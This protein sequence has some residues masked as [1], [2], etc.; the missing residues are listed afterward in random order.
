MTPKQVK[1]GMKF[2]KLT[3]RAV[4][5]PAKTGAVN[6]RHK[7]RVECECGAL[8]TVPI[9]YLTRKHTPKT[10]C[11]QCGPKSLASQ[12]PEE[13]RIWW[14]MH[15]RTENPDHVSYHHYGG[16]GIRVCDEWN[17]ARGSDGFKAFLSFVGP[18]P[19]RQYSI[20]RVD[21][22]LGY[23]PYSSNG[24]V[25]VKWATSVE[26]RANQRPYSN[27]KAT[28]GTPLPSTTAPE[29][30]PLSTATASR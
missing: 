14:M 25:Q 15:E 27:S 26:Q 13:Y 6:M 12:Y 1:T 19:S 4:Y 30:S 17:K 28:P 16:R 29:S 3:V 8:D 20:D 21:N 5:T 2:G 18:R 22:D 24:K 23:Q 9:Y 11:G 10:F 7:C